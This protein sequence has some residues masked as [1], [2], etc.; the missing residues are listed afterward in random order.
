MQHYKG[1]RRV[2]IHN[3]LMPYAIIPVFLVLLMYRNFLE[4]VNNY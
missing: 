3:V 1:R 4:N 2:L